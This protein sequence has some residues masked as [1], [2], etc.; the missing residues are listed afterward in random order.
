LPKKMPLLQTKWFRGSPDD[1]GNQGTTIAIIDTTTDQ[2]NFT[3]DKIE[4]EWSIGPRTIS[5]SEVLGGHQMEGGLPVIPLFWNIWDLEVYTTCK[6]PFLFSI[7]LKSQDIIIKTLSTSNPGM[8]RSKFHIFEIDCSKIKWSIATT[9]QEHLITILTRYGMRTLPE[10][11]LGRFG[12][13]YKVLCITC[14]FWPTSS[15]KFCYIFISIMLNVTEL[16]R[17]QISAMC[18]QRI[19]CAKGIFCF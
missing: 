8:L 17:T 5:F 2:K 12:G 7:C 15:E 6:Q 14:K 4:H 16:F 9:T 18:I 1:Y 19:E 11:D 10:G 13:L 3:E